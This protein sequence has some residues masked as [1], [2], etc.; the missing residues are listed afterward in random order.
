MA[1]ELN[2][3]HPVTWA[4]RDQWHKIAALIMHKLGEDSLVITVDDIESLGE[5]MAVA[6]QEKVDGIHVDLVTMDAAVDLARLNGG[7]H[8]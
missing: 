5:G 6:V 8:S 7:L 3:N 2:P 1:S 4:M